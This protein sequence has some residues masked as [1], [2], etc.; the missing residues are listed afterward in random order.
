VIERAWVN[1]QEFAGN[2]G[3]PDISCADH[4]SQLDGNHKLWV[5]LHRNNKLRRTWDV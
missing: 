2:D 4:I 3:E 5:K 1:I